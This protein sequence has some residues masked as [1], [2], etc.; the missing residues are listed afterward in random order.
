MHICR[1]T[2]C[3]CLRRLLL[4]TATALAYCVM[5]TLTAY[6]FGR[7]FLFWRLPIWSLL[8]VMD[9]GVLLSTV[10]N[11]YGGLGRATHTPVMR[12]LGVGGGDGR[13]D[14][15]SRASNTNTHGYCVRGR[16]AHTTLMI[17]L[18]TPSG[19]SNT[20]TEGYCAWGRVA[21][22]TLMM[23]SGWENGGVG[24]DTIRDQQHI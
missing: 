18:G 19:P 23:I 9:W 22:A 14:T 10:V 13:G 3:S 15:P 6:C 7:C 4:V 1:Y 12:T 21:D 17:T 24:R 11:G 16:V 8:T 5:P 20:N 2:Y